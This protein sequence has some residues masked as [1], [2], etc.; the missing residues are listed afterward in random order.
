MRTDNILSSLGERNL[1]TRRL[2]VEDSY[3]RL[4]R[5]GFGPGTVFNVE[6]RGGPGLNLRS[7]ILGG[8][9]VSQRRGAAILSLENVGRVARFDDPEV[10][11]RI[12]VNLVQVF[13]SLRVFSV[14]A[15]SQ[16]VWAITGD[17]LLSTPSGSLIIKTGREP[18][19]GRPDSIRVEMSGVNLVAATDFIARIKPR[20]VEVVPASVTA[21]NAGQAELFPVENGNMGIEAGIVAEVSRQFFTACGYTDQGNGTFAR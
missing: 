20:L 5:N 3:N 9:T 6:P 12:S 7:S 10:R 14:R 21:T 19:A 8:Y 4:S 13:P 17:G 15:R 18:Y 16:E 11:V 1:G 2:W